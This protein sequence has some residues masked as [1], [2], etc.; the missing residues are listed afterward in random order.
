MFVGAVLLFGGCYGQVAPFYP[1]QSDLTSGSLAVAGSIGI[2]SFAG[3]NWDFFEIRNT[4]VHWNCLK[5]YHFSFV[6]IVTIYTSI[7]KTS[8]RSEYSIIIHMTLQEND[9][10]N[11]IINHLINFLLL[12]SLRR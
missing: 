5:C 11:L 4:P 10:M 8:M 9:K 2:L 1:A 7:Y 6:H 12:D 3:Q